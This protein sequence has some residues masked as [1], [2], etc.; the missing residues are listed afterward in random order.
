MDN[1]EN[2]RR[3]SMYTRTPNR[4]YELQNAAHLAAEPSTLLSAKHGI[5]YWKTTQKI[6]L[7][8]INLASKKQTSFFIYK[9]KS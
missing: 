4:N 6:Y 8:P 2:E 1:L 5:T 7:F 9:W 3:Y